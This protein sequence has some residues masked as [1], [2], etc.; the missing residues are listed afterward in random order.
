MVLTFFLISI[1]AH[2]V[3]NFKPNWIESDQIEKCK[4]KK[5]RPWRHV[6]SRP[7]PHGA[8]TQI[9]LGC[10]GQNS[11]HVLPW[12]LVGIVLLWV[13][14][15]ADDIGE[16]YLR[17]RIWISNT[18]KAQ[19]HFSL[20]FIL[21]IST[22]IL[23]PMQKTF[24]AQPQKSHKNP[25]FLPSSQKTQSHTFF[26]IL[27][28]IVK[29]QLLQQTPKS[30]LLS[31]TKQPPFFHKPKTIDNIK[32]ADDPIATPKTATSTRNKSKG[33]E[34]RGWSTTKTTQYQS[35]LLCSKSFVFLFFF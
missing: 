21:S 1:S 27:T 18:L 3:S 26:I 17:K 29:P 4:K 9:Q 8:S 34:K 25:S 14:F 6:Q 2:I 23:V 7:Q 24:L 19:I 13:K 35:F 30:N 20:V 12:Y 11:P 32:Q 16:Y 15:Q 28:T 5:N 22:K 33:R 10:T 31:S